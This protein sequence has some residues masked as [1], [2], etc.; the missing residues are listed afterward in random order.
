VNILFLDLFGGYP[1]DYSANLFSRSEYRELDF[2][3]SSDRMKHLSAALE[4]QGHTVT[5]LAGLPTLDSDEPDEHKKEGMFLPCEH[6][7][8]VWLYVRVRQ[9]QNNSSIPYKALLDYNFC[10]TNTPPILRKCSSRM[11]LSPPRLIPSTSTPPEK[12]PKGRCQADPRPA[13]SA[14]GPASCESGPKPSPPF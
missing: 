4:K 12:L 10:S 8:A 6:G 13:R 3:E 9:D 1:G 5:V 7:E 2:G 11:P 14:A